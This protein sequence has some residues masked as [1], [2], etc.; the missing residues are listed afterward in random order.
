MQNIIKIF[1]V[2]ICGSLISVGLAAKEI[3]KTIKKSGIYFGSDK[4]IGKFPFY[5]THFSDDKN[6]GTNKLRL[7]N[8]GIAAFQERIDMVRRAKN[9]IILEYFIYQRDTAGKILLNE[10]IKKS[11]EGVKVRILLDKS[12]TIIELDEYYGKFIKEHGIR[13][14]HNNR[15]ID[16]SSAQFR[17]HRKIFAIDGLEAITGGRNIGDDY[18]DMDPEYNFF[19]RDVHITGPIVKALWESFEEFWNHSQIK[20]SKEPK[21]TYRARMF[22]NRRGRERYT[23]LRTE[24]HE[25]RLAEANDFVNNMTGISVITKRIEDIARPILNQTQ[26]HICPKVTY[27]SDTPGANVKNRIFSDYR[28]KYKILRKEIHRRLLNKEE[29]GDEVILMSPY[30]MLNDQWKKNLNY[31]LNHN[32]KVKLYTNSLGSTDAFYVAANFYRIIFDWQKKGLTPMIHDSSYGALTEVYDESVANARWGMHSKTHIYDKD[33][34]YIGTYNIDNRSDFYNAEMGIFCDGSES[35]VKDLKVNLNKR[36]KNSYEIT[37]PGKAIDN[38]GQAADVFGNASEEE[39]KKMK[40]MKIPG[41]LF[42]F[43][44]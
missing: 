18:F 6:G 5:A 9:E 2:I 41:L 38:A 30:F 44:M 40:M 21:A 14:S 10:L 42:E 27:V 36:L 4:D 33:S 22:R 15:A 12:I 7:L 43:L 23:Q 32:K 39:L 37:G 13:L 11:R 1:I 31:L 8:S 24:Q 16:P 29:T 35:L 3:S 20:K 17:T 25:R 19:D 26:T 34:A 28:E